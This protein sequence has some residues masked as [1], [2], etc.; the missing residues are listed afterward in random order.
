LTL[1]PPKEI[2]SYYNPANAPIVKPV[3]PKVRVPKANR[4]QKAKTTTYSMPGVASLYADE[5]EPTT[6]RSRLNNDSY[7]NYDDNE[8]VESSYAPPRAE[9]LGPPAALYPAI[10][11]IRNYFWDLDY[12]PQSVSFAFF[13]VINAKNCQ[14]FG[15]SDFADDS[16]CLAVI[17]VSSLSP[18][19][20]QLSI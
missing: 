19:D 12:E 20:R 18:L 7:E 13:A 5:K 4:A 6:K 8:E 9:S 17:N 14:E 10:H 2:I 11:S 16:C 15:L 1:E 3:A